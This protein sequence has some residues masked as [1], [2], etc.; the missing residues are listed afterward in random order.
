MKKKQKIKKLKAK[1]QN[2]QKSV[3]VLDQEAKNVPDL[4]VEGLHHVTD[5]K[6]K[7]TK[8]C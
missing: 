7:G 4:E 2:R 5:Q 6:E 1:I 8:L 3:I